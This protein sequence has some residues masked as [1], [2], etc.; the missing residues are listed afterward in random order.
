MDTS[1][2]HSSASG[3]RGRKLFRF[4]E[5]RLCEKIIKS[6]N[7]IEIFDK[8]P[9]RKRTAK[10]CESAYLRCATAVDRYNVAKGTPSDVVSELT[11]PS[12]MLKTV[13]ENYRNY[14]NL[15]FD[16]LGK[17]ENREYFLRVKTTYYA[18]TVKMKDYCIYA[19]NKNPNNAEAVAKLEDLDNRIAS[20]EQEDIS[21][22]EEELAKINTA[23]ANM[24]YDFPFLNNDEEFTDSKGIKL[25]KNVETE[26]F[27]DDELFNIV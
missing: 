23:R 3:S 10:V 22:Y 11:I 27:E 26:D 24:K 18:I 2:S 13:K 6:R 25:S 21:G 1:S 9:E 15:N 12:L 20:I 19:L 16:I 7:P 8:L 17:P 4:M 14:D 5:D